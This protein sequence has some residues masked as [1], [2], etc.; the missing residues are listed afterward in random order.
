MMLSSSELTILAQIEQATLETLDP[1]AMTRLHRMIAST[2]ETDELARIEAAADRLAD[3]MLQQMQVLLDDF[4]IDQAE[5]RDAE[6]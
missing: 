6:E 1:D 2:Q 5:W 3:L 4:G